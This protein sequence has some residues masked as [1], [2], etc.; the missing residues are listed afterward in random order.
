MN[1]T[2]GPS[3]VAT[4]TKIVAVLTCFNR[5]PKTLACLGA[6]EAAGRHA[7]V[8]LHAIVVDD[9]STDGTA[10]AV[11]CTHPWVEVIEGT[12]G[13]FW[14]R[15][16]HRGFTRALERECDHYLWINDDTE[17]VVDALQRLLNQCQRLTSALHRPVIV[18]G[19]TAE[20]GSGRITYGGRVARSRFRRF[21]YDIVWS[22]LE[23]IPCDTMEGNCVLIP[24][25]VATAVGNL[26]PVFEHAMGDTDYCLRA[27]RA[28]FKVFVG[29]GIV[30]HCSDNPVQGTYFDKSLPFVT[31][32]RLML[33]RKGLPVRSWLHFTR[34]H[35]G[36]LWPLY[37][38]WPYARLLWSGI[39]SSGSAPAGQ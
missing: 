1:E 24:H 27:L 25:P 28:G 11:R 13:L 35:G 39:R 4:K 36:L 17:L 37:F 2:E 38:S 12:G 9:A 26:D 15:G 8:D 29:A 20:S 22:D 14:N 10:T 32:W 7:A 34:R 6:L 21:T 23:P 31:R 16:M 33:S 5:K 30:G 18:V 19:A 3:R